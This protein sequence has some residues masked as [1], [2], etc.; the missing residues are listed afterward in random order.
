MSEKVFD[1]AVIGGGIC[2]IGVAW[3]AAC[4]SRSVL[5]LEKYKLSS[6]TSAGS[7]RIIHG[8]LRY[9]QKLQLGRTLESMHSQ[10]DLLREY[11]DI[12]TPLSCMM[13]LAKY[14]LKSAFFARLGIIF[15]KFLSIAS[16]YKINECRLVKAEEFDKML[17][18]FRGKAPYGAL[19]WHDAQLQNPYALAIMHKQKI[20]EI[21]EIC[22]NTKVLKIKRVS[23]LFEIITAD[24][25]YKARVV[26]NASGP[27]ADHIELE[28]INYQ[29]T[30]IRWVKAFNLIFRRNQELSHALG[31]SSKAGRLYFYTP[32]TMSIAAGTFYYPLQDHC[33][34]PDDNEL[35]EALAELQSAAAELKLESTDLI[36]LES[37][38][39]AAKVGGSPNDLID[40][41]IIEDCQGYIDL[42]S[43]KYTTFRELGKRILAKADRYL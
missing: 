43:V 8:G 23:N 40:H 29:R 16:G 1:I 26:I 25:T 17:P 12:V 9:L 19:L 13:P 6:A 2:G 35:K 31:L 38:I 30:K 37:G 33:P 24:Q 39:L 36:G 22:E 3:Q 5:L 4:S 27:G 15:Y 21:G 42:I 41:E 10:A 7:L 32:R 11:P 14:G 18:Y 20:S 28:D 34:E